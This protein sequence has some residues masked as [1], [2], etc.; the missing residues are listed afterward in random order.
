MF[1]SFWS[2]RLF[3][4]ASM[5]GAFLLAG[6]RPAFAKAASD[7]RLP[8][9]KISIYNTHS[10]ERLTINYR[11]PSGD[12]ELDAL[13]SINWIL[14]CHYTQEVADMDL[15]VIEYLNLVDKELGGGNEFH[16][17]SGYRSPEYNGLLRSRGRRVAKRSLHMKGQAIDISIPGVGL[18]KLRRAALNLKYGGVGYYPGAGFVHLDSGSFRTW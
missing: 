14:R 5:A 16:I 6:S 9:G 12:Y 1:D 2:R 17:I 13:Q 10:Q 3:L 15:R 4:K 11:N 8:E 18:D 7:I